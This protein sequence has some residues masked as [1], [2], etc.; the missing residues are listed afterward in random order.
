MRSLIPQA[1]VALC[2]IGAVV[3]QA[4]GANPPGVNPQHYQ[5]YGIKKHS[6]LSPRPVHLTDQFGVSES[7]VGEPVLLC[8]PS[9]K[10]N[11]RIPDKKTHLLCYKVAGNTGMNKRVIVENQFGKQEFVVED[12]QLLCVPSVKERAGP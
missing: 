9:S 10:N 12:T 7:P 1:A 2:I 8:N 3:G 11:E 6:E 4:E 5:C